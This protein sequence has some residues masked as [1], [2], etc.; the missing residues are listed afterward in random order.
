M[1]R[2]FEELPLS[3]VH[4]LQET[5]VQLTLQHARSSP[6]IRTQLC[7][8]LAALALHLPPS[9]WVDGAAGNGSGHAGVVYWLWARFG[10]QAPDIALPCMLELLTVLPEVWRTSSASQL[11]DP[12]SCCLIVQHAVHSRSNGALRSIWHL[13]FTGSQH[14]PAVGAARAPP[15]DRAGAV[16]HISGGFPDSDSSAPA[17]RWM[18]HAQ[19]AAS[20]RLFVP[21]TCLCHM[22]APA[23]KES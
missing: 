15:Q 12:P 23:N 13:F 18:L 11:A 6:A 3:A 9:E 1:Q 10:G 7:L 17:V 19:I 5:L 22:R 16:Q 20:C 4:S 8:A 2:D 21:S 14:L